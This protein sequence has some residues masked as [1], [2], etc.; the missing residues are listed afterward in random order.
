MSHISGPA[1][2]D[3]E[4]HRDPDGKFGAQPAAESDVTLGDPAVPEPGRDVAPV[5]LG[6]VFPFTGGQPPFGLFRV[7]LGG[8]GYVTN[9]YVAIAE[10]HIGGDR[11]DIPTGPDTL[12]PGPGFGRPQRQDTFEPDPESAWSAAMLGPLTR[13]GFE[14]RASTPD[15]DPDKA[16]VFHLYR[17]GEH[18]GWAMNV[19]RIKGHTGVPFRCAHDLAAVPRR[20][21]VPHSTW[22]KAGERIVE[23]IGSG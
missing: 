23:R 5:G 7:E 1:Q 10:H 18:A 9:R 3:R 16:H 2:A 14:V 19:S 15:A 20:S 8:A 13:A 11:I 12:R 17:E 6:T 22:E 4:T 21:G